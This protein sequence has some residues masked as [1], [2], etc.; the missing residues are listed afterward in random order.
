M[1]TLADPLADFVDLGPDQT[2][3][4][5]QS[6]TIDGSYTV[7]TGASYLWTADNGFS[8]DQAF[9]EI[10][11]PG[12]YTLSVLT[13]NGCSASDTLVVSETETAVEARFLVSTQAL[14]QQEV[15]LVNLSV[16]LGDTTEWLIPEGVALL[17]ESNENAIVIFEAPGYYDLGLRSTIGACSTES[18]KRILIGEA[19]PD[20]GDEDEYQGFIQTFTVYP[21]PSDGKFT[22]DLGFLEVVDASLKLFNIGSKNL[23][24]SKKVV[25]SD[26]YKVD[27]NLQLATGSYLLLLETPKGSEIRKVL[28]Q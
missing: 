1:I 6:L 9:V 24:T 3:C 8:S 22:V 18:F 12:T 2:L 7:D 23:V 15:A 17:A 25:G 20:F 13:T 4:Q 26:R 21:N 14:A 16:P 19:A 11:Q 10:T 5:G 28:I 27:F